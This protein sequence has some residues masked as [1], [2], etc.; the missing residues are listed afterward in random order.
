MD[1]ATKRLLLEA[2]EEIISLRRRNEILG[3]KVD[4]IDLFACV[5]HTR[6]AGQAMGMS[7]DVAWKIERA[8][9]DARH[10]DLL[11]AKINPFRHTAEELVKQQHAA[12][13]TQVE[14]EEP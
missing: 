12:A 14:R 6:P 13:E 8:I 1:D 2:K 7:E 4:M 9:T 10:G 3:A 11:R 5:L